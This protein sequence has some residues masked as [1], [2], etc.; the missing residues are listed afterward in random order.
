MGLAVVGS[1]ATNSVLEGDAWASDRMIFVDFRHRSVAAA[2]ERSILGWCMKC[3]CASCA[4]KPVCADEPEG[5]Y[6]VARQHSCYF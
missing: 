6:G 1:V 3:V 4:D 5:A 2:K